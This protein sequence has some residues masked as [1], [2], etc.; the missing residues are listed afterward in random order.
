MSGGAKDG[1]ALQFGLDA[2]VEENVKGK[3]TADVLPVPLQFGLDAVVEENAAEPG[4][5]RCRGSPRFNSAS[6][7]SS[8]RTENLRPEAQQGL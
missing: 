4:C 8:R 5:T 1:Y 7:L 3:D 6:T 2:V